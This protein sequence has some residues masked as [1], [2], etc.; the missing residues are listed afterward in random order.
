[1]N[2]M[3]NYL[4]ESGISL[5]LFAAVFLLFLRKE[6]FFRTNRLFL[7][8]SVLFSLMLPL[9]VIPVYAPDPVTLPEI[10]VT[11]YRNLLETVIINSHQLSGNVENFVIS[12]QFLVNIWLLGVMVSAFIFLFRIFQ[13][14]LIIRKGKV[15]AENG[16]RLVLT[17]NE[18]SPFSFLNWLFIPENHSMISGYERMIRHEVEHI[19]QGHTLDILLLDILLI[20]QWFNPFI[21]L[22]KRAVRENH[23]YLVDRAVLSSG[24]NPDEYKQIL[25]SHVVGSQI[26]AASHFNYSLLKNR[27]K[28]MTKIPS[29]KVA[30]MKIIAGILIA[31]ALIV[32]FACEQKKKSPEKGAAANDTV[33]LQK[34]DTGFAI[35]GNPEELKKISELLTSGKFEV[36][37]ESKNGT[38]YLVL[39]EKTAVPDSTM[40]E[41]DEV[42]TMVEKMPEF[43]GGPDSLRRFI[44]KSVEYPFEA[45]KKGMQGKVFVTF[46]VSKDGT[47]KRAKIVRGVDPMLD[48][49]ALRVVNSL[50]DWVPGEQRGKKVNV[51]YTIPISF[52]LQ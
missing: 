10:T 5:S 12:S 16:Y 49:E 42:F 39:R 35:S 26:Y 23:E 34:L 24:V 30:G 52:V 29:K 38:T 19:R 13:I 3:V 8:V 9:L 25:L 21:W 44:G 7:L 1:M 43:P 32:V 51:S 20:F 6:T 41:T 33:S 40:A 27:F 2:S 36:V 47:V 37:P 28:M 11:P 22:L 15:M 14:L 46:I 18:N 45:A 50:P 17:N 48:K 4:L 31:L